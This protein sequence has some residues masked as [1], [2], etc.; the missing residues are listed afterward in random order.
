MYLTITHLTE[1][2]YSEPAWDSFNELRLYPADD[3]RQ[4]CLDFRLLLNPEAV[5]R[6][7]LDYYGN[8]L[9]HFH[10]PERHDL[11]CIE[12][13]SRVVTYPVPEPRAVSASTLSDLR[14]RFFE[15]LS[16]T[17]RVPL[18]RN[19]LA[20]FGALPLR[21]QD[22]LAGYLGALTDYLHRRFRYQP[23][24]TSVDTPLE[25]FA[26]GQAGVC[27]DYAHAMLALCRSV[28]IPM[29]YVSGYIRNGAEGAG[30]VGGGASHA[31]VEA[32]L[33]GNGWVGYD[34]TN[35]CPVNE[36]HVKIGYGR[37]YD[38][39]SPVKGLRRGGGSAL[40]HVSVSVNEL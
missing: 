34:P 16:P 13:R 38:D 26:A 21:P 1:Y 4:T 33:P 37:D 35:G 5:V 3:Y 30:M 32:F 14:H 12:T 31:W 18:N 39:V 17:A 11:L 22:D 10:L 2:R 28:G 25:V 8:R 19:W 40:L 27:Q 24:A 36:D 15:Y 29:R 9:H 20:E 23:N 6:S 7:H